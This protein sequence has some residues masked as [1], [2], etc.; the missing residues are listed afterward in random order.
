ME[1]MAADP[2]RHALKLDIGHKPL[3]AFVDI[4]RATAIWFSDI[5]DNRP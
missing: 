2:A 4:E 5:F 3:L 1:R